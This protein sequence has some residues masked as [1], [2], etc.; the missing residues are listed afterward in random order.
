MERE[1]R[2]KRRN[3]VHYYYQVCVMCVYLLHFQYILYSLRRLFHRMMAEVV[4]PFQHKRTAAAVA[5][6]DNTST[7]PTVT[8]SE[9]I[10]IDACIHFDLC[11]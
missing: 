6:R 4:K 10:I 8:V 9:C 11:N 1:G 5:V 7:I 2:A 3:K